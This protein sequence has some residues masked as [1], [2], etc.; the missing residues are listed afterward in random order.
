MAA[1]VI[2]RRSFIKSSLY[3]LTM[4]SLP[5][6]SAFSQTIRPRLDW[7]TFKT[8]SDYASFYN[9]IGKMRLN[10]NASDPA[11]WQYWADVHVNNCPHS[12]P[13]FFAWHRG[14]L[15]Y[16]EQ[17]LRIVSGNSTL[18]L[19]YWDYYSNPTIPA[20]FTNPAST[21]PLYVQRTNTN[22]S[23]ALTMA[24]FSN[25]LTNFQRGTANAFET[26]METRPHNPV[27][28]IIGGW[29]ATM[30]SPLDPI[31]YLHHANVDRY[32]NAWVAA[33]GG[34]QMPV[35]TDPYWV[36]SMRYASNLTMNRSS[37]INTRTKM[38][39]FYAN[40]TFPSTLPASAAN[41]FE[42]V[43]V[44]MAG[45]LDQLAMLGLG[46]TAATI[47]KVP[48]RPAVRPFQL[49]APRVTGNNRKSVGG[50][51]EMRLDENSVSARIPLEKSDQQRLNT[52][53]K[54][55]RAQPFSPAPTAS[56]PFT[57]IQLVLED[58]S[59]TDLGRGGGFFYNIYLNLPENNGAAAEEGY[60]VGTV[61][62]FQI[63]GAIHHG[64]MAR[65][66]FPLTQLLKDM[67][68]EEMQEMVVSFVRVSGNNAPRGHALN[69]G[70]ARIE[71]SSADIE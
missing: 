14:Y 61:G 20:E 30:Q 12:I 66:T 28:D 62:A 8:T 26:S 2:N 37:T 68:V 38:S 50:V 59:V 4:A 34:R 18:R 42:P 58:A 47:K 13:Y 48:A 9:A 54:K 3:G 23:Q 24:P 16:F 17:Q 21:N 43:Q 1:T 51:K 41:H 36:G 22:I 5:Y 25:L 52:I 19:P 33:G 27:H 45:G 35:A 60:F 10:S 15:Y 70:E 64:N 57:S 39:Y 7:D 44:A 29:M 40:E 67:T 55:T 65:L 53:I 11:S 49:S 71:L 56:E 63:A 69:L 6:T 32:W 46:G 31:F